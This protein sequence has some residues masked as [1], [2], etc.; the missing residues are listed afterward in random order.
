V[1]E[2]AEPL[3]HGLQQ[4]PDIPPLGQWAT[5]LRVHDELTLDKLSEAE[6]QEVFEAL[7]PDEG[8]RLYGRGIRRR[9]APMLGGDQQR[10]RLAFSLLLSLP[11]TP[12]ILYGEEIGMG[13]NLDLPDRLSVRTPMQW[14]NTPSAGFSTAPPEALV[15]PPPA[16][17]FGPQHVSADAQQSDPTSLLNWTEHAIRTRKQ[18]PEISFG[19]WEIMETNDPGVLVHCCTWQ[20]RTVII[21]HNLTGEPRTVDL[22]LEA[23]HPLLNLFGDQTYE[24]PAVGGRALQLD[25]YGYRWLRVDGMTI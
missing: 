6:R 4:L 23:T 1:C 13:E 8:M 3:A 7:A 19:Q 11:G 15:R 14:A 22:R 2:R 12:I 20:G 21:V 9:L 5:F 25:A 18:C 10:I 17:P 16:G 24:P